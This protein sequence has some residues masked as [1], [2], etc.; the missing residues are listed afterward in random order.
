MNNLAVP[1]VRRKVVRAKSN[2]F[3]SPFSPWSALFLV[4]LLVLSPLCSFAAETLL[5]LHTNNAV[6][7]LDPTAPTAAANQT[8]SEPRSVKKAISDQFN[9]LNKSE[10]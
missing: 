7:L 8:A 2:D 6:N 10:K 5:F 1:F 4:L 9:Q 3:V